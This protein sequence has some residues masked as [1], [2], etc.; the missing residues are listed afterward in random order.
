MP[1]TPETGVMQPMGICSY[2]AI[3]RPGALSA[4]QERL[5]ALDGCDVVPSV[6]R[7]LLVVVTDSPD[8]EGERDLRERIEALD[9]IEALVLT[10]AEVTAE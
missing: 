3:P 10:F 2:L 6:N 8:T 7:D 1:T 4:L 9:G 5:T